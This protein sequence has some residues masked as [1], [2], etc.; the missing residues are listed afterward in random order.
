MFGVSSLYHLI[1]GFST[2]VVATG[3]GFVVAPPSRKEAGDSAVFRRYSM[4]ASL[5][6][7]A[8]PLPTALAF[9]VGYLQPVLLACV[10]WTCFEMGSEGVKGGHAGSRPWRFF[11]MVIKPALGLVVLSLVGAYF[12]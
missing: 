7:L 10:V 12:G 4:L 1:G 8:T 2:G 9:A 6:G 11:R 3:I 5:L